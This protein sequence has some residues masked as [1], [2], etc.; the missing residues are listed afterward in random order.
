MV[1]VLTKAQIKLEATRA[2][3]A[4]LVYRDRAGEIHVV[5][6]TSERDALWLLNDARLSGATNT[7]RG[8]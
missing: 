6:N 4:V 2:I 1:R 7:A 3:E 8:E 5:T